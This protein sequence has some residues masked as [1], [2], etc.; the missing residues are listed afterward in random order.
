MMRDEK[1]VRAALRATAGRAV[2]VWGAIFKS[3]AEVNGEGRYDLDI[4]EIFTARDEADIG[5]IVTNL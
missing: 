4:P 5:S 3:A 2:W 1:L